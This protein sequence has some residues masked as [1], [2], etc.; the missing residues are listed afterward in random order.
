MRILAI[1]PLALLLAGCA[2]SGDDHDHRHHGPTPHE[3]GGTSFHVAIY[4]DRYEPAS[5]TIA[6]G[7]AVDW[8]NHGNRAHT[9]TFDDGHDSGSLQPD[10]VHERVFRD[11]G[12]YAYHCK[13]HPSMR[14]TIVVQ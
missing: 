8:L 1:V 7:D 10:Q 11:A 5:R 9:V 13:F 3:G 4:N 14:G 6:V 2:G 12:T